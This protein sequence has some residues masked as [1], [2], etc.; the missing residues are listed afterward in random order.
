MATVCDL[1]DDQIAREAAEWL[2]RLQDPTPAINDTFSEWVMRSPDH[3]CHFLEA[4]A[5]LEEASRALGYPALGAIAVSVNATSL[6]DVADSQ[7]PVTNPVQIRDQPEVM[8][9]ARLTSRLPVSCR[10]VFTLRKVYGWSQ[11]EIADR[12][13]L[14]DQAVERHLSHAVRSLASS[15]PQSVLPTRIA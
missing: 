4:T 15:L 12:L 5:V 2:E 14:P 10:R 6:D 11:Q 7:P 3:L 1:R 8:E 9:L 13:H